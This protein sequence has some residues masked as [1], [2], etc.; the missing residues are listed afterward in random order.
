MQGPDKNML[1]VSDKIAAFLKKLLF[2]KED[3]ANLSWSSQCFTFLSNLRE[4]TCVML[5][6]NL[7]RIFL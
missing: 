7:Q 6:S 4:N 3:T 1:D 5:P 2:L